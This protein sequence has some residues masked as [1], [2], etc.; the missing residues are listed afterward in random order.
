MIINGGRD[1]AH[2]RLA[3][4]RAVVENGL[5]TWANVR[6]RAAFRGNCPT[7]SIYG[8]GDVRHIDRRDPATAD[9]SGHK[10]GRPR[11]LR[12]WNGSEERRPRQSHA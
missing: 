8:K 11:P 3:A 12:E 10:Y 4:A 9:I 5:L 6:Q 7:I 2:A 1:V